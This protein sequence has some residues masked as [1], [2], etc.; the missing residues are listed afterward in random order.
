[1]KIT[2]IVE[3]KEDLKLSDDYDAIIIALKNYSVHSGLSLTLP[4]IEDLVKEYKDK[5]V[6]VSIN[7]NFFNED[8]ENLKTILIKLSKIN[9]KAVLFYD[10]AVIQLVKEN[11]IDIDLVW[12]QSHMVTNY[13]TINY[14]LDK[15]VNYAY[16]APEITIADV[17]EISSKTKAKLFVNLYGRAVM[18]FSKRKLLS[19]YFK[20]AEIK[21]TQKSLEIK[22]KNDKYELIETD[23]GTVF[24]SN[25]IVNS[26]AVLDLNIDYAVVRKEALSDDVFV[27]LLSLAQ[28][29]LKGDK[30]ALDKVE[31]LIGNNTAFNFKKTIYKVGKNAK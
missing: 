11:K 27:Q 30:T 13:K 17:K 18:S 29:Y 28:D 8:I 6:F 26:S 9:I 24:M 23:D 14:Y 4:E 21:S 7:K 3:K 16:L 1:M 22:D 20:M 31:L 15:G 19:N 2:V 5:E 10:Q 25:Y 12:N